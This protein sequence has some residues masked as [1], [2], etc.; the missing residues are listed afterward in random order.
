MKYSFIELAYD[1]LKESNKPLS[2]NEMWTYAT[3]TGK[4]EKLSSSGKT[5]IKTLAAR[6][7]LDGQ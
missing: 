7:Y 1:V 4:V 2:I 3:E 5:P 6:I